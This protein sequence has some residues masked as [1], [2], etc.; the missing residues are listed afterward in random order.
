MWVIQLW[1]FFFIIFYIPQF[2]TRSMSYFLISPK[3][4]LY[5]FKNLI[6]SFVSVQFKEKT[7]AQLVNKPFK[8]VNF[9]AMRSWKTLEDLLLITINK[10]HPYGQPRLLEK[11]EFIHFK[12]YIKLTPHSIY[13]FIHLEVLEVCRQPKNKKFPLPLQKVFV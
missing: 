12:F 8:Y 13:I 7:S 2:S 11:S 9:R 3:Q 4:V 6:V 1:Y 5:L 10:A